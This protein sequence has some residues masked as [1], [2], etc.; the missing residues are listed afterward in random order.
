MVR[1]Y[2]DPIDVSARS[3]GAARTFGADP[4]AFIWRGRLHA[5]L[6]VQDRW[7]E[8]REWW[9]DR[10]GEQ[11]ASEALV[12]SG[13]A[14]PAG[15]LVPER[16]VWRVEASAGRSA[17]AGVFELGLDGIDENGPWVLLRAQD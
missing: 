2:E 5:V 17:G 15:E 1:R 6:A 13:P 12:P 16:R 4:Q 10:P 9:R 8:R 7:T 11:P 14:V 3:A